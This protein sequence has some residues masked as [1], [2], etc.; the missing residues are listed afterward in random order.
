MD[1]LKIRY[2]LGRLDLKESVESK[3]QHFRKGIRSAAGRGEGQSRRQIEEYGKNI[4][5]A[6]ESL[7][8]SL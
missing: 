7:R 5:D 3:T 4:K 6:Y 2:E 1:V 8:K